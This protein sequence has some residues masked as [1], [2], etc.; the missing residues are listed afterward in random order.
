MLPSGRFAS[1]K[2]PKSFKII[3][4]KNDVNL[5]LARSHSFFNALTLDAP[6]GACIENARRKI[7][8][9]FDEI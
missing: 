2:T 7:H 9:K 5:L 6:E 1:S 4:N 3:E 8:V